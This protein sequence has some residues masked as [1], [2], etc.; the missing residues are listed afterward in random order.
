MKHALLMLITLVGLAADGRGQ[1]FRPQ[2]AGRPA[3]RIAKGEWQ[4]VRTIGRETDMF[5]QPIITAATSNR[6]VVVDGDAMRSFLITGEQEWQFG[7]TGSGPGEFRQILSL[8]MDTLGNTLVY[9]GGLE[10]LTIIDRAGKLRRVIPLKSRTDRATFAS[11]GRYLLLN[12]ASDSLSRTVDS[13]GVDSGVRSLPAELRPFKGLGAEMSSIIPT[14]NGHFVTFRWSSRMMVLSADGAITRTCTGIDSLSFPDVVK[15]RVAVKLEGIRSVESLR[16]D[17]AATKAA[18]R[19]AIVGENLLIEPSVQISRQHVLDVYARDCGKYIE[20]RPF[21]YPA[22]QLA[23]A[24]DQLIATLDE[25]VPHV[26]VLRW[27]RR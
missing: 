16:I 21:P 27:V 2:T 11:G 10:R 19:A 5:A 18:L 7:R 24:G 15:R 22:I 1:E 23:A 3:R 6:F 4:I 26:V 17:P 8:A 20:S 9:D 25:P 12:T 14:R 13:M